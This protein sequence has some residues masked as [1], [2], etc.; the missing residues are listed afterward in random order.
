MKRA[1]LPAIEKALAEAGQTVQRQSSRSSDAE[2]TLDTKVRVTLTVAP[3]NQLPPRE[4]TTL[5]MESGDDVQCDRI[6]QVG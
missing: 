3:A 5:G 1:A 6:V 2:N 4:T